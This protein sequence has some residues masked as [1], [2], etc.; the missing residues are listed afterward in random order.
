M[1]IKQ[2]KWIGTHQGDMVVQ[3]PSSNI[4]ITMVIMFLGSEV[5]NTITLT[6]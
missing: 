1:V 2:K 3:I 6:P 4:I 5:Y